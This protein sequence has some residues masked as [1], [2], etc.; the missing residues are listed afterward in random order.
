MKESLKKDFVDERGNENTI[1]IEGTNVV[2]D[3]N[4]QYKLQH[5][6]SIKNKKAKGVFTSDIGIH[7]NGFA[8]IMGLA[9]ILSIAGIIIAYIF[10]KF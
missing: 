2:L 4:K 6:S 3:T 9:T 10:L 8:G 7:S 5:Q 1:T